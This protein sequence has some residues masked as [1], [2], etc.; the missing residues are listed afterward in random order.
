MNKPVPPDQLTLACK[1]AS[2]EAEK[3]T[4]PEH[5]PTNRPLARAAHPETTEDFD[6]DDPDEDSIVLR[7][8]RATAIYHNRNG[9]VLI[10]QRA[11]WCDDSD[12][13]VLVTE[14]NLQTLLDGL[15]KRLNK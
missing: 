9:E 6:W 2:P 5:K 1:L 10:R 7:E 8:Q 3:P 11:A 14:E 13:F 12:S 15:A 4:K